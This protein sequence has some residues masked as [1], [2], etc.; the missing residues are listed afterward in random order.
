MAVQHDDIDAGLLATIGLAGAALVIAG[1]YFAAGIY[2]EF[3]KEDRINRTVQPLIAE[4]RAVRDAQ[5]S[6]LEGG[7]TPIDDAKARVVEQYRR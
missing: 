5:L 1:A 3:R 2:W 6:S 7:A 4:Q